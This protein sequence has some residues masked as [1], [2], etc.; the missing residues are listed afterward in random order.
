MAFLHGIL[1]KFRL[2]IKIY[3]M[4][5]WNLALLTEWLKVKMNKNKIFDFLLE[6]DFKVPPLTIILWLNELDEDHILISSLPSH[7]FWNLTDIW[8]F[9]SRTWTLI[10]PSQLYNLNQGR[11]SSKTMIKNNTALGEKATM[12]QKQSLSP[13]VFR[14]QRFSS[15]IEN[16]LLFSLHSPIPT[17]PSL[18][19]CAS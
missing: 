8:D 5:E 14:H 9:Q 15:I 11:W 17:T 7:T 1:Q 6:W 19:T 12:P 4:S 10:H 16:H 18:P 3:F 2:P 13:L